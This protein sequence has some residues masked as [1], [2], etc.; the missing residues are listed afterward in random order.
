MTLHSINTI[1]SANKRNVRK[2]ATRALTVSLLSS[3][4]IFIC[5]IICGFVVAF[6]TP[7]KDFAYEDSLII[8]LLMYLFYLGVPTFIAY[9]LFRFISNGI[10]ITLVK[11]S[12][13]K[14]PLVY[15]FGSVGIGYIFNLLVFLLFP[16]II[17]NSQDIGIQAAS[18]PEVLLCFLMYA[19]FPAILEELLFRG[20]ILK[21]LLPYGKWGAILISALLFGVT[22]MNPRQILFAFVIGVL[23]GICYEYTGSLLLPMMIH[24][25]NNSIS[26]ATTLVPQESPLFILLGIMMYVFMGF[27]IYAIVY[28]SRNGMNRHV[29]S[30]AGPTCIGHTLSASRYL[31]CGVLNVG[32]VVYAAIIVFLFMF[33]A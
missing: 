25:I 17:E 29:I 27:G 23:L 12:A 8:N 16:T 7:T 4:G 18:G 6:L 21:H 19:I 11:R 26:V 14:R 2:S 20:L 5:Q 3:A 28:Y 15:I 24:L 30:K 32:F 13:P 9:V 22:H 1:E 33:S 10:R 31:L